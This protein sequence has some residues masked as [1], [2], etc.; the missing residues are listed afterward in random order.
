MDSIIHNFTFNKQVDLPFVFHQ[1]T[2]ENSF[3]RLIAK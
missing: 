2:P 3:D 1:I